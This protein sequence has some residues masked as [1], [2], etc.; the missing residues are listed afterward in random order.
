MK[1]T[2][3][4]LVNGRVERQMDV[5][6]QTAEAAVFGVV[7]EFWTAIAGPDVRRTAAPRV[8]LFGTG[9]RFSESVSMDEWVS[10][11]IRSAQHHGRHGGIAS[12]FLDGSG[13]D[14]SPAEVAVEV[15]T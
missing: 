5:E 12:A 11:L 2:A 7:S 6:F 3:A 4:L 15:V 14:G 8:R 9:G 13:Q 1:V 10:T